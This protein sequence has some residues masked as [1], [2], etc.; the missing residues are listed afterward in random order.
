MDPAKLS[1][2]DAAVL[3]AIR[4]GEAPGA[5]VL[6]L[7]DGEIAFLRAYGDRS[8]KPARA[9]MTADT[10]F[11]LASLTKPIVTAT[12]VAILAER[13]ALRLSDKIADHLPEFAKNGKDRVTIEHLLLHTSGLTA[14]NALRD[15]QAGRD[16]ALANVFA[17]P[18]ETEPGARFLY[19][20]VGYIV[21][22]ALIERVSG[23]RLDIK[24]AAALAKPTL[25]PR[26]RSREP[27]GLVLAIETAHE[28]NHNAD[29]SFMPCW[30][31]HRGGR[32][33]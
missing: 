2:I 9:P 27:L 22:G 1:G 28:T 13:G 4:S 25:V 12:S 26:G 18:L 5:V 16:A 7:H 3:T 19:S 21:L 33:A 30:W 20:D 17:L 11:D 32:I 23:E 8:K 6:V 29:R 24:Y 31:M 15:Y 10:V 14:D